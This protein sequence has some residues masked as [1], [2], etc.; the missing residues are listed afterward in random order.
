MRFKEKSQNM[1]YHTADT[2][3]KISFS[4][5]C[6]KH[7][8][9]LYCDDYQEDKKGLTIPWE[10]SSL[11]QITWG[12]LAQKTTQQNEEKNKLINMQRQEA[13]S[14]RVK[15]PSRQIKICLTRSLLNNPLV[16]TPFRNINI[17]LGKGDFL[18]GGVRAQ[19]V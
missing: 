17:L 8:A 7:R 4:I 11:A 9:G 5:S 15:L 1:A 2:E 10:F 6:T 13:E 12:E 19:E 18:M 14:V 3:L 16:S